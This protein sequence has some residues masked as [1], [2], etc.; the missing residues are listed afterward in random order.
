M[1]MP[2]APLRFWHG[3][4][5]GHGLI[6]PSTNLGLWHAASDEPK[7]DMR[8]LKSG[9]G[10]A[11]LHAWKLEVVNAKLLLAVHNAE[12]FAET[13]K[14]SYNN[15]AYF[16]REFKRRRAGLPPWTPTVVRA[17]GQAALRERGEA[18]P[19]IG[20]ESEPEVQRPSHCSRRV[21]GKRPPQV[22]APVTP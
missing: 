14:Y 12:V 6:G 17:P 9:W 19:D 7:V 8:W 20:T 1:A 2:L 5:H 15:E 18:G 10:H 4:A 13:L 16:T 21:R 22:Q 3:T 11:V